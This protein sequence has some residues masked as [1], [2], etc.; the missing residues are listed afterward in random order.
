MRLYKR[1]QLPW[2]AT[3]KVGDV[4]RDKRGNLRVVRAISRHKHDGDLTHIS[5]TIKR[6]SWTGSGFTVLNFTDIIQRGFEPVGVRV[7]LIK[8]IDELIDREIKYHGHGYHPASCCL[9]KGIA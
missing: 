7:R 9:V 8:P 3:L 4:L 5:F 2:F 6:C 1:Q